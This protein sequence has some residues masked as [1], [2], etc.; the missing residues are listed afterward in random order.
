MQ[1]P[2]MQWPAAAM[3]AVEDEM[4][5]LQDN[6]LA[7]AFQ[8]AGGAAAGACGGW[9]RR[10]APFKLEKLSDIVLGR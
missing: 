9:P 1:H 3:G 5:Q 10:Q 7:E 4:A 6:R 8:Y 2:S